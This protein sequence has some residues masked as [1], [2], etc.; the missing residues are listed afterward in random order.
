MARP[1]AS[2]SHPSVAAPGPVRALLAA[3]VA[4]LLAAAL[5]AGQSLAVAGPARAATIDPNAWYVL[6]NQHSG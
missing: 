5:A 2:F 3:V 6:V 4:L 1:A